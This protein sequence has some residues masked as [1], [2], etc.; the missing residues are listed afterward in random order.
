MIYFRSIDYFISMSADV[1]MHER[2]VIEA[3][4]MYM[5]R[6]E[7]RTNPRRGGREGIDDP[8]RIREWIFTD[9]SLS[10]RA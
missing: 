1:C 8:W 4:T 5:Y 7:P 6:T 3:W 2:D 10:I 9:D